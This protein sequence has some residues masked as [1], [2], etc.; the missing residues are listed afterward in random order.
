MSKRLFIENLPL[1]ELPPN[2]PPPNPPW[3][4]PPGYP[5]NKKINLIELI[6]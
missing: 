5:E 2:P 4:Y 1:A 3:P 6:F